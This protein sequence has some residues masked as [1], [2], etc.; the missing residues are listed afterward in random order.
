MAPSIGRTVIYKTTK[1][2]R[3]MLQESGCN[4]QEELPATIVAVWGDQ[5]TSAVNLKVHAD[6]PVG[7]L[8]KT[9][10]CCAIADTEGNFPEGSWHW[11]VI[12]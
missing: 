5:P 1:E 6:G 2:E 7:D 8:W 4:S 9:S 12:K 3:E 10:M 11:P